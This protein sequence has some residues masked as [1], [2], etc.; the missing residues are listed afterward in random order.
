MYRSVLHPPHSI[1]PAFFFS[2]SIFQ[3]EILH[4]LNIIRWAPA[5]AVNKFH[6]LGFD[7]NV[8]VISIIGSTF[9]DSHTSSHK[10]PLAYLLPSHPFS[11]SSPFKFSIRVTIFNTLPSWAFLCS[12]CANVRSPIRFTVIDKQ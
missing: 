3:C 8:T 2:L 1:V 4:P 11:H 7:G 9:I 5:H 10:S 6:S 12:R